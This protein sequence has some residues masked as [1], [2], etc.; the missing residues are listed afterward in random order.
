MFSLSYS[1]F[2][3][4]VHFKK[5]QCI[6]GQ[7]STNT[8]TIAWTAWSH[9]SQPTTPIQIRERQ[10]RVKRTV[11]GLIF[12]TQSHIQWDEV[13]KQK[14]EWVIWTFLYYVLAKP[15]NGYFPRNKPLVLDHSTFLRRKLKFLQKFASFVEVICPFIW[16]WSAELRV[17]NLAGELKENWS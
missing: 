3:K 10:H 5:N 9:Q 16:I 17:K 7:M 4:K 12:W 11:P 14:A 6:P 13:I 15:T 8:L 2:F 1:D